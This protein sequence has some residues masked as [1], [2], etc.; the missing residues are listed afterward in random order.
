MAVVGGVVGRKG[1]RSGKGKSPGWGGE[2][3]VSIGCF[4]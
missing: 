2:G 3:E 4:G 1:L